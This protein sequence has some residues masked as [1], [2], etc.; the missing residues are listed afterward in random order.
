MEKYYIIEQEYV[1]P[2]RQDHLNDHAVVVS[3]EPA[4][5]N[6]SHEIRVKGW[7]GTT[8]DWSVNAHGEYDS[9]EAAEAAIAEIFGDV[10]LENDESGIRDEEDTVVRAYVVGKFPEM[11]DEEIA[12]AYWDD[13]KRFVKSD[14]T[15]DEIDTWVKAC[16]AEALNDEYIVSAGSLANFA[17]QIRDDKRKDE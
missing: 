16:V 9:I 6:S 7:C 4:T 8:N 15:D 14:T 1:G 13:V 2:N 5:T 12:T 10:R 11:D 17:R 3:T